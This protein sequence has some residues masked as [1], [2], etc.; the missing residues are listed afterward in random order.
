MT[1]EGLALRSVE[2]SSYRTIRWDLQVRENLSLASL[3][4]MTLEMLRLPLLSLFCM[5]EGRL[6][7][8]AC[9]MWAR[10]YSAWALQSRMTTLPLLRI[11]SRRRSG[12]QQSRVSQLMMLKL[13]D[14]REGIGK[15]GR[16]PIG[17]LDTHGEKTGSDRGGTSETKIRQHSNSSGK[18]RGRKT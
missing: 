13:K 2:H 1:L 4:W 15:T 5:R 3:F 18:E 12:L 11:S 7:L 8:M 10:T 17:V 6:M 9:R 14:S 16:R